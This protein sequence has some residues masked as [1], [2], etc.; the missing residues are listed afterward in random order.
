MTVTGPV[1]A[2]MPRPKSAMASFAP[3][4]RSANTTAR[5]AGSLNFALMRAEG[6]GAG[7]G[8]GGGAS[9]HL[10][11]PASAT[12]SGAVGSSA[13]AGA[14]CRLFRRTPSQGSIAW[15]GGVASGDVCD[16]AQQRAQRGPSSFTSPGG[17]GVFCPPSPRGL[18]LPSGSGSGSGSSMPRSSRI[19]PPPCLLQQPR[20]ALAAIHAAPLLRQHVVQSP[21]SATAAVIVGSAAVPLPGQEGIIRHLVQGTRLPGVPAAAAAGGVN[22]TMPSGARGTKSQGQGVVPAPAVLQGCDKQLQVMCADVSH[23]WSVGAEYQGGRMPA[24]PAQRW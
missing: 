10:R 18:L 6:R 12:P 14:S 15:R 8:A 9:P 16:E 3:A 7:A 5:S 1:A 20:A 11:R 17:G 19:P 13:M 2:S 4:G 23:G 22:N 24:S 21:Q